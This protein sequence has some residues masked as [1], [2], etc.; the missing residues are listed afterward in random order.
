MCPVNYWV[1]AHFVSKS[2]RD[3]INET[4][5]AIHLWNEMWIRNGLD[6]N[7]VYRDNCIYEELQK[8]YCG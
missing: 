3:T 7:A 8:R 6:K 2:M 5:Y 4:S 1:Y